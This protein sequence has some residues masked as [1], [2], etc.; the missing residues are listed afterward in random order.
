M[1]QLEQLRALGCGCPEPEGVPSRIEFR[2]P[3]GGHPKPNTAQKM[4][5]V[6]LKSRIPQSSR[7]HREYF[8]DSADIEYSVRVPVE[9]F[10]EDAHFELD[11]R[12]SLCYKL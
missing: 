11:R 5:A 10:Y 7:L 2:I 9:S 3:L 4:M 6:D 12:S 1:T 8:S